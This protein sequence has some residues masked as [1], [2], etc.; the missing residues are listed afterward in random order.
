MV[1]EPVASGGAVSGTDDASRTV[2]LLD[3]LAALED[4]TLE[5]LVAWFDKAYDVRIADETIPAFFDYVMARERL[6]QAVQNGESIRK[7]MADLLETRNPIAAL[8]GIAAATPRPSVAATP[9]PDR[10]DYARPT[11]AEWAAVIKDPEAS[12]GR[13]YLVA[14]CIGGQVGLD[15]II[16]E[17]WPTWR[18]DYWE[19]DET[20]FTADEETIMVIV[21]SSTKRLDAYVTVVGW[22]ALE[23][24]GG[25]RVPHFRL[26]DHEEPRGCMQ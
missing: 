23:F 14:S 9:K 1:S 25:E 20:V 21:G 7:P 24:R 13:H 8:A 5:E 2:A 16:G 12:A 10:G 15:A 19:G 3:E 11:E 17:S 18:V 22:Y 4:P 6:F 26:D